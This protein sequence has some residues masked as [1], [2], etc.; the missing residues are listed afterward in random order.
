MSVQPMSAEMAGAETA[1][2]A[3]PYEPVGNAP[4]GAALAEKPARF[5]DVLTLGFAITVAVWI[6]A[7]I[8]R[9]PLVNAGGPVTV[10]MMLGAIFFGG[11]AAGRYSANEWR[12]GIAAGALSGGL[13]ILI[14]GSLIHDYMAQHDRELIPSAALWIGG[15]LALNVVVAGLGAV[16]GSLMPSTERGAIRWPRVFAVVLCCATLPLIT[17]GGLVTAFHAGMAVPDWPQ[18]FQFNMFLFPLSMMQKD[19]GRFYEHA[20]RLMG[21]LVGLTTLT[22]AI[23]LT[24]ADRR[25]WVKVMV[26]GIFAA[27]CVQGILGGT[28]VTENSIGLAIT[29]GVFAQVVFAAMAAVAAITAREFIDLPAERRER[30][31]ADW[32]LILTFL[33]MMIVQLTLGALVRHRNILVMFHLTL[34]AF[35]ALAGFTAGV[36]AWGVDE[37]LR[38]LRRAGAWLMTLIG[39]QVFL[40][41]LALVF[42][43]VP[44][45]APTLLHAMLTTAHQANGAMLLATGAVQAAWTM[46]TLR[47]G[48]A[49]SG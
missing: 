43:R 8:C 35:V 41:V 37:N 47:V 16:V 25:R 19:E 17:A 38:A 1:R 10:G 48:G 5:G 39:V 44:P 45:E 24:V 30:S 28:R 26:W 15:S 23:Y 42:R 4:A 7:Y 18:S 29:H 40:G 12:A 22:L 36:R 27:V 31:G 34:A 14:V 21:T 3:I 46:R 49:R 11:M 32:A 9:M 33:G 13:D 6:A 20:H 2:Q